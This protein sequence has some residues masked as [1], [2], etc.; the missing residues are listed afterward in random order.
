MSRL[1]HA[2]E[3]NTVSPDWAA[4]AKQG[5]T[6]VFYMG[7]ARIEHIAA[8]LRRHGA[9]DSL[10]AAIIAHATLS[11]QR[12]IT[13][14]LATIAA[15]AAGERVHSPALLVVG[16]VVSLHASLAWFNGA[17]PLEVSQTA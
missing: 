11:D 3:S 9:A 6:A 14:T 13:G 8:E 12:V 7:L 10:P 2:G 16:D 17:M 15:A 4:L 1:A 5:N